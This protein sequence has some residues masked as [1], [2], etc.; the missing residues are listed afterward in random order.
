[1]RDIP[2]DG[3]VVEGTGLET[4]NTSQRKPPAASR[5]TFWIAVAGLY[6]VGLA[7]ALYQTV[8]HYGTVPTENPW[9]VPALAL[10]PIYW[11]IGPIVLAVVLLLATRF[12]IARARR[13]LLILAALYVILVFVQMV[14]L[15]PL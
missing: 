7:A 9:Y 12:D 3:R 4:S 6:L 5:S 13:G 2:E 8:S 11:G 10:V 1:M 14:Y 15:P